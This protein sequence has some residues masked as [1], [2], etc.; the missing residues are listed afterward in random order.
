MH[1]DIDINLDTYPYNG[2]TTTIIAAIMGVPTITIQGQ[3]LH[4]LTG[5]AI[6]KI[7]KLDNLICNDINEYISKINYYIENIDKLR[8]IQK[9]LKYNAS[10]ILLNYME[11]NEDDSLVIELR[12]IWENFFDINCKSVNNQFQLIK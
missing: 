7:L 1:N 4:S 11:K 6:N 10:G 12:Y 5:Q 9:Y 8:E 3:A 2:T